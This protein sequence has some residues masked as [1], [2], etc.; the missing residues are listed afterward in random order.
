MNVLMP[1][2][3]PQSVC[4]RQPLSVWQKG[5]HPG[6]SSLNPMPF[7]W[8]NICALMGSEAPSVD[9]VQKRVKVGRG[10]VQRIREDKTNVQ[11]ESI[12]AIAQAF[13]LEAWQLLVPNLDA[14]NLP[15]LGEVKV[16]SAS[17]LPSEITA[18]IANLDE[19]ERQRLENVLRAHL[20]LPLGKEPAQ[21][22][23]SQAIGAH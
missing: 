7:L 13:G 17:V 18:A 10:I 14:K 11:V 5:N 4:P 22:A 23:P 12:R 16:V 9:A 3:V 1:G 15:R 19:G 6:M 2:S 21:L 8:K 20:G